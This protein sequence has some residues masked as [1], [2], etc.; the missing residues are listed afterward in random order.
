M[1][2]V[3]P[4]LYSFDMCVPT[5]LCL[6]ACAPGSQEARAE[7]A[8]VD[9]QRAWLLL[10]E[11]KRREAAAGVQQTWYNADGELTG[12]RLGHELASDESVA[13]LIAFPKLRRVLVSCAPGRWPVTP[14]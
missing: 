3:R 14:A 12:I 2:S 5:L 4:Q 11:V 10:G 9:V 7:P 6:A 1:P 13:A 8:P